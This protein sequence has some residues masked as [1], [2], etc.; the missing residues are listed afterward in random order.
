MTF[1]DLIFFGL[2]ILSLTSP[3]H[4]YQ[5]PVPGAFGVELVNYSSCLWTS[6]ERADSQRSQ[7]GSEGVVLHGS[8]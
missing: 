5:T 3:S 6:L 8:F 7:V 1:L 2:D 4:L